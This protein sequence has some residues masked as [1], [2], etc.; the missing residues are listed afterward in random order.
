V[1][2]GWEGHSSRNLVVVNLAP[3]PA[4]ARVHVPWADPLRGRQWQ[5]TDRLSGESFAREGDELA[6]QGLY[7][8][9]D[10][11]ASH[12]LELE[13]LVAGARLAAAVP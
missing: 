4:Q 6:E 10:G 1:A 7:V 11:W 9:L 3:A 5:L 12:F 8:G 2:W 13:T